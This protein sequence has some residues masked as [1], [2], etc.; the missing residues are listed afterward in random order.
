MLVKTNKMI[1]KSKIGIIGVGMV[2]GSLKRYFESKGRKPFLYDKY[3]HLGSSNEVNKAEIIFICV[4]TP[5]DQ[6]KSF[7][8]SAVKEAFKII[9]GRKIIVLKSTVW[10]HTTE[11][12]Q[13][14]YP[15]HKILF[16]P[17]FLS[18]ATADEDMRWPDIQIVGYTQKSRPLAKKILGLLPRA[19]FE[20]IVPSAEAEMIKYFH[21]VHGAVKVI[22]ANQMYDL[23]QTL[24]LDYEI[25]RECAAASKHIVTGMYLDVWQGRYRGYG[26]SC[27]PKDIRALI[28]F[29]DEKG[30]DLTLLKTA[31]KINNQL[32]KIQKISNPERLGK[33]RNKTNNYHG[34]KK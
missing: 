34:K 19:P 23:C 33:N 17:E 3:N 31:E 24:K 16:N 14:K 12:F 18:E 32:M 4:P 7:D 9:S 29:G 2:G 30:A 5:F 1:N 8:L 15:Q 20:K 11:K 6:K 13:R 21:N 25:I 10:P 27:F 26:G 22:F 28:Q